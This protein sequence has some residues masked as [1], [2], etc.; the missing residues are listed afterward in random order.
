MGEAMHD[1]V[2]QKAKLRVL[3]DGQ[4]DGFAYGKTTRPERH[5]W[6]MDTDCATKCP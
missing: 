1:L 6:K 5:E 4:K 3:Q 2:R